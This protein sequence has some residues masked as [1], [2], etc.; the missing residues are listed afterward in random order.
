[1]QGGEPGEEVKTDQFV[2][3]FVLGQCK[4]F[5]KPCLS[6]PQGQLCHL[7][8]ATSEEG[9]KNEKNPYLKEIAKVLV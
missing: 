7:W 8:D 1:M 5:A 4:Q 9:G 6:K 3:V 2:L